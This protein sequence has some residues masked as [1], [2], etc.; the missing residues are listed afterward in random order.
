MTLFFI[1]VVLLFFMNS[2]LLIES[3]NCSLD[4]NCLEMGEVFCIDNKCYSRIEYGELCSYDKQCDQTNQRCLYQKCDCL[5]NYKWLR[6]E[7]FEKT[8]CKFTYDCTE[9]E[10]C[11][12]SNSCLP[13]SR[14]PTPA[15]IA[16]VVIFV[17]VVL[18]IGWQ[19]RKRCRAQSITQPL[20]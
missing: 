10:Y 15:I 1:V 8:F 4:I 3:Q 12:R 6:T 7:C 2:P 13:R 19:I 16:A 11:S 17:V 18:I 9:E 14:S 20:I 5:E